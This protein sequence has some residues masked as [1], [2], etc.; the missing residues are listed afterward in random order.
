MKN[1]AKLAPYTQVVITVHHLRPSRSLCSSVTFMPKKPVVKDHG[2]K[3]KAKT[4]ILL[5]RVA[6]S[7]ARCASAMEI[8]DMRV[9]I[10]WA[11]RSWS[12]SVRLRRCLK[13]FSRPFSAASARSG[14]DRDLSFGHLGD[15]VLLMLSRTRWVF[16]MWPYRIFCK[17]LRLWGCA[18][19]EIIRSC[20]SQIVHSRESNMKENNDSNPLDNCYSYGARLYAVER[21][22]G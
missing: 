14:P 19:L 7:C 4:V 2:T 21:A 8:L 5:I 17:Y 9:V 1:T 6:C 18:D 15:L 13:S 22:E 12:V 20:F 10:A 16:W 11:V 3:T